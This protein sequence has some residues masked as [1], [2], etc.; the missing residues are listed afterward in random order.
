M[1]GNCAACGQ[2]IVP[3]SARY[4]AHCGARIGAARERT[5]AGRAFNVFV[6]F[7]IAVGAVV[8]GTIGTCLLAS[9]VLR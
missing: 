3:D 6:S 2:R 7:L 1:A 5:V 8:V 9:W 4:C